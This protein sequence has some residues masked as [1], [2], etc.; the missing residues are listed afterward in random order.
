MTHIAART[1]L[2]YCAKFGIDS[3][4]GFGYHSQP[5]KKVMHIP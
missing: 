3:I 1:R 2:S 5:G 4:G